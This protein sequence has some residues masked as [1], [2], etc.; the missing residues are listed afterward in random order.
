MNCEIICVGTELLTGDTLNTHATYLSKELSLLSFSVH[1]QT[2]IGDN[3]AR[4]KEVLGEAVGRSE[5][6]VVTG[7]LG[8]TQDDLTKET[9][10]DFFGLPMTR[11]EEEVAKLT[12]FFE[13]RQMVMTENNL[14]QADIPVGA[15]KLPNPRGSAPGIMVDKN[16]VRVFLLPGPPHEMKGMFEDEVLPIL[17]KMMDHQVISR[18]YNLGGIGESM[19]EDTLMDIIDR[20]DNP[21]IATYAKVGEVLVRITASGKDEIEMN[22]I[23]DKYEKVLVERLGQHIFT[24]SQDP[25]YIAVGKLL[26]EK[27]VTI[28]TAESCTGGLISGKLAEVP[29]ISKSLKMGLVTYSNEAKIQLLDVSSDTLAQY[30]AVSAQTAREMCENLARISG[31]DLTV[32]VTGIAGP[33]GGTAEKPVGLVYVGI[34]YLGETTIEECHFGGARTIIQTRVVN[35]ALNLVRTHILKIKNGNVFN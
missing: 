32:S 34:H 29:G 30:G 23:L 10:A 13:K 4:L 35:A 20:Q 27:E 33:G 25:L 31:C 22:A 9:V 14:R 21:T 26:I 3:P 2:T 16:G 15:K 5:M 11:D 18:Y 8:P 24:H 28:A 12:A 17:E 7:G 6:I 19:V 1:Y